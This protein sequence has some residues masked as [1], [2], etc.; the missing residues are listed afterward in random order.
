VSPAISFR[1]AGAILFILFCE[2][3]QHHSDY[4]SSL[5]SES[6]EYK[7]FC[8]MGRDGEDHGGLDVEGS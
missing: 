8:Q 4:V 6:I 7:A 2:C 1:V 5:K 3:Y